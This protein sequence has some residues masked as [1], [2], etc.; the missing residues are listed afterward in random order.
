M[1]WGAAGVWTAYGVNMP[2]FPESVFVE[3]WP[4]Y[5]VAADAVRL[6]EGPASAAAQGKP[7]GVGFR[8]PW[9]VGSAEI[10]S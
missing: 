7:E 2:Y 8:E 5:L 9:C 1:V 3:C 4:Q 6:G 10:G